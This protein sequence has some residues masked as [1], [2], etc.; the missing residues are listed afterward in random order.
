LETLLN[1]KA[2]ANTVATLAD[3]VGELDTKV[4]SIET[5]LNNYVTKSEFTTAINDINDRLTWKTLG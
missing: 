3:T 1:G 2:D 4:S 5:S